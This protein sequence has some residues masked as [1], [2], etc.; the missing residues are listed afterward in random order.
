MLKIYSAYPTITQDIF[1]LTL[2]LPKF[3]PKNKICNNGL[4]IFV[5]VL[6]IFVGQPQYFCVVYNIYKL[7]LMLGI[8]GNLRLGLK[9]VIM[10]T[11]GSDTPPLKVTMKGL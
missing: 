5:D 11:F 4:N 6:D 2:D 7:K 8:E 1:Q 3:Y 9:K 10:I